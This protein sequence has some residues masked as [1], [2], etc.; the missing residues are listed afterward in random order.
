[1][2]PRGLEDVGALESSADAEVLLEG[3]QHQ[4][5]QVPITEHTQ[6]AQTHCANDVMGRGGT[7]T[8]PAYA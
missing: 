1:M 6:I 8:H 7:K 5:R 3:Q 2:R 4:V